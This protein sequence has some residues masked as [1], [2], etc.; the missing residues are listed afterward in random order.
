MLTAFPWGPNMA[1]EESKRAKPQTFLQTAHLTTMALQSLH[2][3]ALGI[4]N[5][6]KKLQR[7]LNECK[8]NKPKTVAGSVTENGIIS[9]DSASTDRIQYN[10]KIASHEIW[11]NSSTLSQGMIHAVFS[12]LNLNSDPINCEMTTVQVFHCC[13]TIAI[14]HWRRGD[15]PKTFVGE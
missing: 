10:H 15:Q 13:M 1:Q 12:P 6:P 7:D 8:Q 3:T 11:H 9:H 14:T 5:N 2:N 4:Y